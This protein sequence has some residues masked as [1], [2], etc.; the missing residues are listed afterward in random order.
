M[1]DVRFNDKFRVPL[2]PTVVTHRPGC[3]DDR[4]LRPVSGEVPR[5]KVSAKLW[6]VPHQK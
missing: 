4:N 6:L 3:G 5:L 2:Q 1:N